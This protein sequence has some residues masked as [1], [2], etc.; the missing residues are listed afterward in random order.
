MNITYTETKD[1]D[2]ERVVDIFYSVKFLRH[3]EKRNLYKDSIEKAFKNSQY[4]VAA[5]DEDKLIGFVRVLTDESLFATIWNLIVTPEYQIKGIGRTLI[6][7]CLDKYPNLHF[8][9]F[10]DQEVR[11]FYEKLG[12]KLHTDGM[13][14]EKGKKVCVIYN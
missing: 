7:K 14:L 11:K 1:L 4:V 3:P 2:Y 12:F 9:T 10:A 6:Q 8:F 5:Y 13:Y